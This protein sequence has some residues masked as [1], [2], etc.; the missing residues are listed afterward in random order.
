VVSVPV[1]ILIAGGLAI[2]KRSPAGTLTS[3]GSKRWSLIVNITV[4][5][6]TAAPAAGSK[7]QMGSSASRSPCASPESAGRA[8]RL[9]TR[10]DSHLINRE[11]LTIT[12]A[13]AGATDPH[14]PV[15]ALT[16]N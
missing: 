12:N 15:I 8:G 14:P 11:M 1:P 3:L 9:P 7:A 13:R 16:N 2:R 6:A 4:S 10:N 5:A